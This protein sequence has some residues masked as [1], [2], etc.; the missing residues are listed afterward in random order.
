MEDGLSTLKYEKTGEKSIT[1]NAVY[2][3]VKI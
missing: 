3:N 2:I 1:D